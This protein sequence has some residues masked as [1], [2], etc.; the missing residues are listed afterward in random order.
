METEKTKIFF[1]I[2][3]N[4]SILNNTKRF[5]FEQKG[6][7]ISKFIKSEK[8][9]E[10]S[11]Y[12]IYLLELDVAPSMLKEKNDN[13]IKMNLTISKCSNEDKNSK[14]FETTINFTKNRINF[15]FEIDIGTN[16]IKK[17]IKFTQEKFDEYKMDINE[18]FLHFYKKIM[19]EPK[20]LQPDYL[21]N[22]SED[23]LKVLDKN[24]N[25]S[26]NIY[27]ETIFFLLLS[28][29]NKKLDISIILDL[30]SQNKIKY[31]ALIYHSKQQINEFINEI[32]SNLGK[33]C[34]SWPFNF[35][36]KYDKG[37]VEEEESEEKRE[38][39]ETEDKGEE[40]EKKED[41][42]EEEE[43]IKDGDQDEVKTNPNEDDDLN[44]TR[45]EIIFIAIFLVFYSNGKENKDYELFF[46][47]E[48]IKK[49]TLEILSK[50]KNI[51]DEKDIYITQSCRNYFMKLCD[52]K[53]D[54]LGKLQME[55]NIIKYIELINENFDYLFELLK[56][57]GQVS[58][59]LE[60]PKIEFRDDL[61]KINKIHKQILL[62]ES[63]I[64]KFFLS[65]N[66]LIDACIDLFKDNNL[67]KLINLIEF[68][69]DEKDIN[70]EKGKNLSHEESNL[71]KAIISTIKIYINNAKV[72]QSLY[73]L[74]M[75][76]KLKIYFS[77]FSEDDKFLI[78]ENAKIGIGEDENLEEK[79]KLIISNQLYKYFEKNKSYE[80]FYSSVIKN[81]KGIKYL[82]YI[83]KIIPEEKYNSTIANKLY[84]W[85]KN[86]KFGD[87]STQSINDFKKNLSDVLSILINHKEDKINAF[88]DIIPS[89]LADKIT[90]QIY[91]YFLESNKFEKKIK[92]KEEIINY[93]LK[94]QKNIFETKETT[95][96]PYILSK[97]KNKKNKLLLFSKLKV[98]NE[99]EYYEKEI[100]D[101]IKLLND[102]ITNNYFD[103]KDQMNEYIKKTIIIISSIRKNFEEKNFIYKKAL[104]IFNNFN[105]N[106][107]PLY[108]FKL[109]FLSDK[110][111]DSK[112]LNLFN[113]FKKDFMKMD[114]EIK[115][116]EQIYKYLENFF[117]Q[118]KSRE[119]LKANSLSLLFKKSKL[120]DYDGIIRTEDFIEII[121]YYEEAELCNLLNK[122][123]CFKNIY[124][125][126]NLLNRNV[127]NEEKVD[128]SKLLL[129][130]GEKFSQIKSIF[131]IEKI[132]SINSNNSLKY[133]LE[134]ALEEDKNKLDEE[135]ILLK[136]YFKLDVGKDKINNIKSNIILFAR[137]NKINYILPG[138]KELFYLFEEQIERDEEINMFKI[139]DIYL[140]DLK[141]ENIE[142]K[143]IE[144]IMSFLRKFNIYLREE[145]QNEKLIDKNIK[146]NIKNREIFFEFIKI[147]QNN[148]EPLIFAK[149]KMKINIKL[150][151]NFLVESD[152][153]K[154]LQENDIQGFIKTVEFFEKYKTEKYKY[155]ELIKKINNVLT[156]ESHED[157]LGELIIKY[158]RNYNGIKT[159]YNESLNK[160]ESSSLIISLILKNSEVKVTHENMN[161]KYYIK[162]K[163]TNELDIE[164][165]EELRGKALIMKSYMKKGKNDQKL[166][167][168]N[169]SNV[170]KFVDLIQNFKILNTYLNDLFNIGLPEPE[171]YIIYI[172]IA[173]N[174][175]RKIISNEIE[176]YDYSDIDC[177]MS[178]K[179]FKLKNLINYLYNLKIEIQEQT[180]KFYSENEYIRFFYGKTFEYINRNIKSK[181]FNNLLPLFKSLTNNKI[182][183]AD[184][185]FEYNL[186]FRISYASNFN[187]IKEIDY[188]NA[189]ESND[190][191][192]ERLSEAFIDENSDDRDSLKDEEEDIK[193]Y[194]NEKERRNTIISENEISSSFNEQNIDPFVFSFMNMMNNISE[195]CKQIFHKNN[196]NSCEEIYKINQV[197]E[198][199]DKEKYKG[200]FTST[201]SKQNNDKKLFICYK[202][203]TNSF[204]TRSSLLICNEETTKEE[205][206]SFLFRVFLCPCQTLFIISKS[207]SL[208]KDN[209]IFLVEKVDEFLKS[210]KNSMKS[211][212][213]I[214][215]SDCE[216]EIKNGFNNIRDVQAFKFKFEDKIN[217]NEYLDTFEKLGNITVI[218][219]NSCGEGKSHFIASKTYNTKKKYIYFQI[220]GVF[221]RKSL[222]ERVIKQMI[223]N[224]KELY[225]MN[226]DLTY[227]ELN[228]LVME[229][230]F[231]FLVM[232]YYD[233]DNK[234][235]F[236]NPNQIEIYIETHNEINNYMEK[237]QILKFCK[238]HSIK[239]TPLIYEENF[240][241]K[242]KKRIEDSKIQIVSNIFKG[243]LDK[244]IGKNNINLRSNN[245]INLNKVLD[246]K[247]KNKNDLSSCQQLIDYY[248]NERNKE[249]V[250]IK[251]P[252]YYQKNMFINLLSDQFTRFTK[253]VI[254][255]PSVLCENLSFKFNKDSLGRK[256]TVEIRELIVNS[257]I[258]NTKLFVKG[259]Y[260]NLMK[261]QRETEIFMKSE[262]E[263]NRE[264][265][266]KLA[267]E[268][269][270]TMITYDNIKQSII[271]FD[272]NQTS[273][274]F[275]IIPS[276]YCSKEEYD[277]LNELYNSQIFGKEIQKLKTPKQKDEKELLYD[278]LDL[279]GAENDVKQKDYAEKI[280][281]IFPTYVF[282]T[283][284][285]IK[286][287]HILMKTRARIPIIM[288]GETGC[289][290]TSLIKM[291]SLIKNKGNNLR[292]KI[293][294]IHQGIGDK[295]IINFFDEKIKEME[296]EDEE[297]ILKEQ[298]YFLETV[299]IE[300]KLKKIKE[301]EEEEKK[302]KEEVEKS[303]KEEV[304]KSKKEKELK[305]KKT[306]FKKEIKNGKNEQK[307]QENDFI[308]RRDKMF[309]EIE[310]EVKD[311]QIWIF[312]DEINTCN[313]MGL[314]SEIF[315]NR[316]YRGKQ[317]PDRYI[318][319]GACNPY[320]ILSDENKKLELGLNL[321]NKKQKNLVYTVNPLPHSLLNYVI[322]FGELSKKD[323]KLYIS[324]M[325]K[326]VIDD[327]TLRNIAVVIVGKCHF[328][329]QEKSD[330]SSVSLR[331][332][333]YFN[334][335]YQGFIR[336]YEYLIKLS[337]IKE[338]GIST[339]DKHLKDF[340][341]KNYF[342][343][344][345]DAINLSVYISYY[346]RLP[347]KALREELSKILD[348]LQD[349]NRN[350]YFD[351]GF[352]HVPNKESKFIL[353]QIYINPQRGIA[354]NNALRENIFCELFCLI[355]KVPLIICGKPGNSKT[356]SVQLLL[357]N[358]K[359]KSSDNEF[360]K[361]PDY[362]EV[363]PY[364]FQGSTTC[365]SKGVLK[366]FEKARKFA[367]ENNDMI[368][369]VFFDEM[370]LAEESP[371]NPLKV[372]HAEL[373]REDNK[374]AFIGISNYALDASKMN[375]GIRIFCQEPDEVDLIATS[376]EIAKSINDN[377]FNDN[378][379]LFKYLSQTYYL[380]RNK[381][382]SSGYKDFHGNRDFYHLIRNTMK[383]LKEEN[384]KN[385]EKDPDYIR[386]ISAIKALERNFGGYKG[387]VEEII[388]IFYE[389]S[390][391]NDISH[392]YNI[393]ENISDNFKDSNSRYLLLISKNSTSQNLIEQIIQKEKK[394][395]VIY[396]G[397]Q[398]K[399]DKSE[400]YTEEMLYK[401]QMQMENEVI[402]ILKGLEIIYPS[403]YDLFNQNFSE[404][405][406]NKCAKISFSNNQSTSLI[407]NNFKI[408]VLVD[409]KMIKYEDKPFLNRFE[410]H[411]IS[412]EN[413]LSQDY[414]K[415]VNEINNKIEE[416]INYESIEENKDIKINLKNQL[417]S[418]D[419]EVIENLVFNLTN[420]EKNLSNNKITEEIFELISPTLSQDIISFININGFVER[421]KELSKII[422]ASYNKS[423]ASNICEYLKNIPK[424]E[425]RH[426]I[427]TFSNIT[428]PIFKIREIK[429]ENLIFKK[430]HTLEIVI[431]SIETTKKLELL[432]EFFYKS[433]KNLCIIKFEEEDL[434]K[435]NYVKNIIDSIEKVESTNILKYYLFIVYMKRELTDQKLI[436]NENMKILD[437]NKIIKDQIPLMDNFFQITIDNLNSESA[438]YNI[439]SLMSNKDNN[440]INILFDL[441]QI[442]NENIYDCISK[443]KFSFKNKKNLSINDYKQKLSE[444][445]VKSEYLMKK[446]KEVLVK[447][448]KNIQEMVG[449]ILADSNRFHGNIDILS[450]LKKYYKKEILS[451]ITKNIYRLEKNNILSS[452]IF[453]NKDTYNKIIDSFIE[454][455]DYQFINIKRPLTMIFGLQVP[456]TYEIFGKMKTFII[457]N[458]IEKYS[459]NE[460]FL[461]DDLPDD[462][463]ENEAKLKYEET[464]KELVNNTRNQINRI[465]ELNEILRIND[466]SIIKSFFNDLYIIFLS[467]KNNEISDVII[468][469]LDS[470]VQIYFLDK[471]S[472]NN[473]DIFA[474]SYGEKIFDKHFNN[475]NKDN[476]DT[477]LE[478]YFN[479]VI[480]LLLFLQNYSE[481]IYYLVD[482]YSDIYKFS[483]KVEEEFIKTFTTEKFEYEKSDRC[484][485][486]FEIINIKLF[487][488]FESMIFTIKQILY[489]LCETDNRNKVS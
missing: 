29:K 386:N 460:N 175:I 70:K 233:Y 109:L 339:K 400:S 131:E 141:K 336:Y 368:S 19:N 149:S 246:D 259:P 357:D 104:N 7:E 288:M 443:I 462:M 373:E 411:V 322:D 220:G 66:K 237:Y 197:T 153:K 67:D 406:G 307:K 257:L 384:D 271:A 350:K 152:V 444:G 375:R 378:K 464:K 158:I 68:I 136:E 193:E 380:F 122:S 90:L 441:N 450:I 285:Y 353:N 54:V 328:F 341:E 127:P 247:Q 200:V 36:Q 391:Y 408:V 324:S 97:I 134:L 275:K 263:R 25:E 255:S 208:N 486:Y 98:I 118:S 433:Q 302:K 304:E 82:E 349:I 17:I 191:I 329:I 276:S 454:N 89:R 117:K 1:L 26:I 183:K 420:N 251:N 214:F 266:N 431:D 403:L 418:C 374:V 96:I 432:I 187:F 113:Q 106:K 181:N 371:E 280:K 95:I 320:R 93:F 160:S 338:Y 379:E 4:K 360:F 85:V 133:L 312:L 189:S 475:K 143:K 290:K 258:N 414:A 21:E 268:K 243:L 203:I 238:C 407:N 445:I 398:F 327:D 358:M 421:E 162:E 101:N 299:K 385:K 294:N 224:D 164:K 119:M 423:Y 330:I 284:N 174:N 326:K 343:L 437:K 147:I 310:K 250:E 15:V 344:K 22:L 383:Y 42:N 298:N 404:F 212:L 94:N 347:T 306:K 416:L 155:S 334:I 148:P 144:E 480:K 427:Y 6:E 184:E 466:L 44:A 267:K 196:I 201:T 382:A 286:M 439:F 50:N 228:E 100:T 291:L 440:I 370:G 135:L 342:S 355:N 314:I 244:T 227:T 182:S 272:D 215:H 60:F 402:L 177:K 78:L 170:K 392:R 277:T 468:K 485:E 377:I 461:R 172:K 269:L 479:D 364:T 399:G 213:I 333:K 417:I 165:I 388:K 415:L 55:T 451:A 446:L 38:D 282:T 426:I 18:I 124:E 296:K 75:I 218:K 453:Y 230:L 361:N 211:L 132:E 108:K 87:Y 412:F 176:T 20:K 5:F 209:K 287:I 137:A 346:L 140:E 202:E 204:P 332:I 395:S 442:I 281:K 86:N 325:I 49:K 40:S 311:S 428:E 292:M 481:Y 88:L 28:A 270:K 242:E 249:N 256:K 459:L 222:F 390:G 465:N 474:T 2:T 166:I 34:K 173:S 205:I 129:I 316:S 76:P 51:K 429:N 476:N 145:K 171:N 64:N 394:Q 484:L 37:E 24:K 482:I 161:I 14:K 356:L 53:N 35:I 74:E 478:D 83:I 477:D 239:L 112:S 351:Y 318:L 9:G 195:Y 362:K 159:L 435:M 335:F 293:L 369:L 436:I 126:Q 319:I 207:D 63:K 219:S 73:Y 178:G 297:L 11:N 447:N 340:Q 422:E 262:E 216:S 192:E 278:I 248:F 273:I 309:K 419:K 265:I 425:L 240:N 381:K 489:L 467:Y 139:L 274:L 179:E 46:M 260:E 146:D 120:K 39:E 33:N 59:N 321:D 226:I 3:F 469:F 13:Y 92:V 413:I 206:T 389:K 45:T 337:K 105:S 359:G 323:T 488:I 32:F 405:N 253:S 409:E 84:N 16:H 236:Y 57:V 487:K 130:A 315:C 102:L 261:E 452:Y 301:E 305:D 61:E 231:K 366:T 80:K 254:L 150:L 142:L 455:I 41:I 331:D 367:S 252:N 354:K 210:Y 30:I 221:T 111:A 348:E 23:L 43:S 472:L 79:L 47:N 396:I 317:L 163:I 470:L 308:S 10:I 169:Y 456:A 81:I 430:Q 198:K 31:E 52:K 62:K 473:K 116:L 313:S 295:E 194:D 229:F 363:M 448:S 167:D 58:L 99:E 387:S 27:F 449:D 424:T 8:V 372:L 483:P 77:Y 410:K 186:N 157:Y 199:K 188:F 12:D 235:F 128:E 457:N 289:G 72:K 345:K 125:E 234:T 283:D 48:R 463:N 217:N 114:N 241:T 138:M 471:N 69:E 110:D 225:I 71:R 434:N 300:E 365:T 393:I 156:V 121:K 401:I 168:N 438:K 376:N 264:E 279:C 115:K 103:E 151:L 190:D 185:N 458:I 397:S 245:L 107:E 123:Y 223:L 180:E 303:K 91:T 65:F 56:K 154:N 352:L 232:K